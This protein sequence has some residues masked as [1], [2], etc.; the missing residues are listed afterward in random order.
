MRMKKTLD[1]VEEVE[2]TDR[3]STEN[4]NFESPCSFKSKRIGDDTF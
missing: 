2:A 1:N 4:N 3:Q